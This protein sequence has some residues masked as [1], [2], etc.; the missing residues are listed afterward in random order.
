M[1]PYCHREAHKPGPECLCDCDSSVSHANYPHDELWWRSPSKGELEAV[2]EFV[3][4]ISK[5]EYHDMDYH[6]TEPPCQ[7]A[8]DMAKAVLDSLSSWRN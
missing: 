5:G 1:C 7:C 3:K 4:N 2:I 8:E 6:T